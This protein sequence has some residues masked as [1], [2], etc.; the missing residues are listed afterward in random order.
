MPPSG[1]GVDWRKPALRAIDGD[2]RGAYQAM[3]ALRRRSEVPGVIMALFADGFHDRSLAIGW[4]EQSLHDREPDLVS[5]A[6]DPRFDSL[7]SD[8]RAAPILRAMN[9]N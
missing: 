4:L 7:R 2:P 3:L 8:P 9:L 5:L 1:R 6:F